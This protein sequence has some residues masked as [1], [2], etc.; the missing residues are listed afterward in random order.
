MRRYLAL[1]PILLF[2]S[3]PAQASS[4]KFLVVAAASLGDFLDGAALQ[5]RKAHPG[6]EPKFILGG[7]GTLERQ[8][9]EGIPADLFISAAQGPID[10]LA[11]AGKVDKPGIIARNELVMIV[12]MSAAEKS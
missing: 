12:P 4:G 5:Y 9:S 8:I 3:L 6:A 11:K 7:S 10:R 2:L 1:A